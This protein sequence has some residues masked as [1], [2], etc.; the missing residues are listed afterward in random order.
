V[1]RRLFKNFETLTVIFSLLIFSPFNLSFAEDEKPPAVLNQMNTVNDPLPAKKEAPS[2]DPKERQIKE[3]AETYDIA[4]K[5]P[6][7]SF[8]G[9]AEEVVIDR[10]SH[11]KSMGSYLGAAAFGELV[12]YLYLRSKTRHLQIEADMIEKQFPQFRKRLQSGITRL[13]EAEE[14]LVK[15]SRG[16]TPTQRTQLNEVMDA[17]TCGAMLA[18]LA[19][20]ELSFRQRVFRPRTWRLPKR[21]PKV[22]PP[23]TPEA[24]LEERAGNTEDPMKVVEETLKKDGE[25]MEGYRK[26]YDAYMGLRKDMAKA[27]GET[28]PEAKSPKDMVREL[29][30]IQSGKGADHDGIRTTI[31]EVEN[32]LKGIDL[33]NQR[34]RGIPPAS[35]GYYGRTKRAAKRMAFRRSISLGILLAYLV[36]TFL[37]DEPA[38]QKAEQ[39][40]NKAIDDLREFNKYL[41]GDFT[42]EDENLDW[43]MSGTWTLVLTSVWTEGLILDEHF[44]KYF[45]K[46]PFPFDLKDDTS[47]APMKDLIKEAKANVKEA[48]KGKA[49]ADKV[50]QEIW[51]LLFKK[52]EA[53]TDLRA[54]LTDTELE[55]YKADREAFIK[56]FSVR[57]PQMPGPLLKAFEAKQKQLKKPTK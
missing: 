19:P 10:T 24:S 56:T 35:E 20:S 26:W 14:K 45:E 38:F 18:K 28:F 36:D 44:Q 33:R 43:A 37:I 54:K 8:K 12:V 42:S 53:S 15:A 7:K 48:N 11:L 5:S 46:T 4:D 22:A 1:L 23:T 47:K 3:E 16:L 39:Q 51:N 40:A 9:Q 57:T 29:K 30:L 17:K 49:P 34:D 55:Q 25:I 27:T 32:R 6:E 31:K 41:E 21:S 2:Q 52:I 13:T 50:F